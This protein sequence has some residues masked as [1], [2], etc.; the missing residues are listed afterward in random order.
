MPQLASLALLGALLPLLPA[1]VL[2]PALA[3][4]RLLRGI[5]RVLRRPATG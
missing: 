3:I 1:L 4:G 2:L 5:Y